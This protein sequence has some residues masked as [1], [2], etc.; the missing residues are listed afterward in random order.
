MSEKTQSKQEMSRRK[1]LCGAGVSLAG[2]ALGGGIGALLGY[3][4]QEANASE[5]PAPS[6]PAEYQLLDPDE[7]ARRGYDG[8]KEDG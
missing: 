1:F 2:V 7:A 8:Y 6:W 4:Q 3:S 5:V